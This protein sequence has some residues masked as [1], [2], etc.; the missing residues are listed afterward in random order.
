[1]GARSGVC[2]Q[3]KQQKDEAVETTFSIGD[4]VQWV[5]RGDSY[6]GDVTKVNRATLDIDDKKFGTTFG[7]QERYRV[8]KC[9]CTKVETNK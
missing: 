5:H 6:F 8:S 3:T 2:R 7:R 1:M 9:L 4:R